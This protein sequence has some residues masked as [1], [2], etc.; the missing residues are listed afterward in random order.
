MPGSTIPDSPIGP[1]RTVMIFTEDPAEAAH[2]WGKAL[3]A[4]VELD[5]E[6]ESVYAWIT[7]D[8]VEFGWHHA[9]SRNPA[10]GS[11]VVYWAVPDLDAA[12]ERLLAAG[13]IHHRGPLRVSDGRW[14]CQITDPYGAIHGLEGP[15]PDREPSH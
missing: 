11:T 15:A 13:A 1:V 2:W 7:V 6:G 9:E 12:R 8:G 10:G 4:D 5:I 14:I 3:D